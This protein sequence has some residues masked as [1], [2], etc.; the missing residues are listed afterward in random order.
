MGTVWS[1]KCPGVPTPGYTLTL[2]KTKSVNT[3]S[4]LFPL[5]LA[6][7]YIFWRTLGLLL[8]L[9]VLEFIYLR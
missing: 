1:Q 6:I 2:T 3:L 8:L 7:P 5:I 4:T 9:L